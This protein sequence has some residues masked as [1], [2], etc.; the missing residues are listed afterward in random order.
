MYIQREVDW[1]IR[2]IDRETVKEIERKREIVI[3]ER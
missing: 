2:Y 3:G 1:L